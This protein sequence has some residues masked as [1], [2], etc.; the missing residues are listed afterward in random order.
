M[1]ISIG[2]PN[3]NYKNNFNSKVDYPFICIP[4]VTA[5]TRF[6]IASYV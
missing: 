3:K 4:Y 6:V 1:K 2:I 5:A